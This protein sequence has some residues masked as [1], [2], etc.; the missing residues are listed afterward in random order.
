M[1][2]RPLLPA[3]LAVEAG[4]ALPRSCCRI[5][6]DRWS[7]ANATRCG[8]HSFTLMPEP[9]GQALKVQES[10]LAV[11][12]KRQPR[13]ICAM[14]AAAMSRL[15]AVLARAAP[16]LAGQGKLLQRARRLIW[17]PHPVCLEQRLSRRCCPASA[18]GGPML[19]SVG[20]SRTLLRPLK[21]IDPLRKPRG[22]QNN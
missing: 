22:A 2:R 18:S 1:L 14:C 8:H 9:L 5:T 6:P 17:T 10:Q 16:V 4:H 13:A 20:W 3:R 7:G 15:G 12:P 21:T 19:G 11:A